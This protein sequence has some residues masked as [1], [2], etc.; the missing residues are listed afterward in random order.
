MKIAQ[1]LASVLEERALRAR[2]VANHSSS[3]PSLATQYAGAKTSDVI[4]H[5]ICDHL[6]ASLKQDDAEGSSH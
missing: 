4:A 1:Q 3:A 5:A 6:L 2:A